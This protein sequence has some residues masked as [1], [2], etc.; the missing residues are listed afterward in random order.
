VK[1][2]EIVMRVD[3]LM[4][5][6]IE[7]ENEDEAVEKAYNISISDME[8]FDVIRNDIVELTEL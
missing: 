4:S 7:A 3:Q 1:E 6:F 2:F 5:V 8:C